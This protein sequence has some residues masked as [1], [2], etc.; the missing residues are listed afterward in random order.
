MARLAFP[1][2]GQR[3]RVRGALSRS[4]RKSV[5]L[6][7]PFGPTSPPGEVFGALGKHG[8]SSQV[9]ST[10]LVLIPSY[11][12]GPKLEETI[13]AARGVWTPVL[14]VIDGS[15]DGSAQTALRLAADDPGLRVL[16]RPRNGG[17]GRAVLDGLREAEAQGFSHVLTL[18]ADG[19]HPV[20]LI[21]DFM[22]ASRANPRALVLGL[23]VF[24]ATAPRI[25]LFG[26]RIANWWSNLETLRGGIG[27][28]L[29][30]FRVYPIAALRRIMDGTRFMRGFDFEPEAAIRFSWQGHPLINLPAPIRY[31]TAEE[32]GV[33]HFH[34]G[35]DNLLLAFMYVRLFAEFLPR[36]PMLIAARKT[37]GMLPAERLERRRLER[38]RFAGRP[39]P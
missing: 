29:C 11:N 10:H 24:D 33:S 32:G 8:E 3:D 37:S 26:R 17:K 27:D 38:I 30:G 20:G 16:I 34:Y 9:S 5:P 15:T 19:Q 6:T 1:L 39:D 36:L 2:L 35:R 13:R 18:D 31:F 23:P 28:C 12:T 4:R 25:R 14:V 7:R 21:P 22:A